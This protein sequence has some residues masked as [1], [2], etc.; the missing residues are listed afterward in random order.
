MLITELA[1]DECGESTTCQT[2]ITV[3]LNNAPTAT[4]PGDLELFVCDLTPITF[5]GFLC[6]DID[7][8]LVSC[9]TDNGT[10]DGD[11]VTFTPVIGTNMITLTAIDECGLSDNK[12]VIIKVSLNSPPTATCPGDLELFLCDLSEV[13][14]P[15]FVCDDIDGNLVSCETNNG[16]IEGSGLTFIPVG[17]PMNVANRPPVRQ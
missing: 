14:L 12:Q 13:T 7:G 16:T 6:D 4:V 15:G 10:I 2:I 5:G 11:A 1:T 8:N 3:I 17:P 9:E